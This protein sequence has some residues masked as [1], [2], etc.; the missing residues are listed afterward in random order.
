METIRPLVSEPDVQG[1]YVLQC[2][3]GRETPRGRGTGDPFPGARQP[4]APRAGPSPTGAA[5]TFSMLSQLVTV[6]LEM[7]HCMWSF[8]RLL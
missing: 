6:A 2:L 5:A 3:Q 1:G 4:G 8:S 7:G